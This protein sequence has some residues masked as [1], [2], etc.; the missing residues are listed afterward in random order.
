MGTCLAAELL[1]DS[2]KVNLSEGC[3][4]WDKKTKRNKNPYNRRAERANYSKLPF[5][6]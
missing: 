1:G 5:K 6:K 2:F 3:I 4:D